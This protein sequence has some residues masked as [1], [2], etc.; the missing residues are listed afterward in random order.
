MHRLAIL[1][2]ISLVLIVL[3]LTGCAEQRAVPA[4]DIIVSKGPDGETVYSPRNDSMA[5]AALA[6]Y[7][8]L[9]ADFAGISKDGYFLDTQTANL[10]QQ[11]RLLYR[12]EH[13]H[14]KWQDMDGKTIDIPAAMADVEKRLKNLDVVG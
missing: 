10:H 7:L 1:P 14:W 13:F 9:K 2:L 6:Q 8:Q 5:V 3:A 12:A 11:D 4:S